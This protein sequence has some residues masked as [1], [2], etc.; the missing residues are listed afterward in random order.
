[1]GVSSRAYAV[2]KPGMQ[3]SVSARPE[4]SDVILLQTYTA[5][6]AASSLRLTKGSI[7]INSPPH[8]PRVRL[9]R[10]K[11]IFAP[12]LATLLNISGT[13]QYFEPIEEGMP[14]NCSRDAAL[15]IRAIDEV[16]HNGKE[17]NKAA[18][19]NAFGLGNLTDDDFGIISL[20]LWNWEYMRPWSSK[21][22]GQN[23][24][25]KWCDSIQTF[26]NGTVNTSP[27][28]VGLQQAITGYTT[29]IKSHIPCQGGACYSTYN[30]SRPFYT[31]QT[32]DNSL[33]QWMWLD[34]NELGWWQRNYSSIMSSLI[35]SEYYLRQCNHLFPNAD[36]T[37]GNFNPN[38]TG[39][40]T[41]Y[42]GW[43][44]SAQNLYVVNGQ[45]DPWRSVSLSSIWAPPQP[46]S[47]TIEVLAGGH[48]C[49]DWNL[50][51][52]YYNPDVKRVV[53]LG[54]DTLRGWLEAWYAA[55]PNITNSLPVPKPDVWVGI[56][57]L[58][59][60]PT[61]NLMTTA[62]DSSLKEPLR[63]LLDGLESSSG[64]EISKSSWDST[65][66][67]L[68]SAFLP[69][70]GEE[71]RSV[72]FLALSRLISNARPKPPASEASQDAATKDL[73]KLFAPPVE[74]RLSTTDVNEIQSAL[75]FLSALFQVDSAS[76]SDIFLRDGFIETIMESPELFEGDEGKSVSRGVASLLS[77]AC[78]SKPCR[79]TVSSHAST[80]LQD[81]VKQTTDTSLR[82]AAA[83][84]LTKLSRGHAED[85]ASLGSL[86]GNPK[87]DSSSQDNTADES[88]AL[89]MKSLILDSSASPDYA[90]SSQ[91]ILDAIEGLAYVSSDASTKELLSSDDAFLKRLFAL[92][93]PLRKHQ[94]GPK[95]IVNIDD[96]NLPPVPPRSS[97]AL[98][99]GIA[100]IIANIAAF[101][102]HLTEE[103]KQVERL[104]RMTKEGAK[105]GDKKLSEPSESAADVLDTDAAVRRRCKRLL[106]AGAI[107]TLVAISS[108]TESTGIRRA[109]GKAF[110]SFVEDKDNRGKIIQAG[111]VKALQN[112]IHASFAALKTESP[113]TPKTGPPQ[114]DTPNP[115]DTLDLLPIQ[116]LAKLTIT[117]SP[118]LIF[119]PD[120]SS[121]IPAIQPLSH[122]LLHPSSTLLQKFE[123]LMALTNLSSLGPP[124]ASKI[125]GYKEPS[126]GSV[127][128][129]AETLLLDDNT[130][131]RRAATEILCNLVASDEVW[132]R[133]TGETP[134]NEEAPTDNAI[135]NRLLI[136]IAMSDVEDTPTRLA[137]S[138]ALAMLTNSPN[139]ARV[140]LTHMQNGAEKAFRILSELLSPSSPP[141][142]EESPPQLIPTEVQSQLSHR[143]AVCLRNVLVNFESTNPS[144]DALSTVLT[145][146]KSSGVI[147]ALAFVLMAP[148]NAGN[149]DLLIAV[150][151]SLKWL[152]SHGVQIASA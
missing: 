112:I 70:A 105:G 68:F 87:N 29:F 121:S 71:A 79:S 109:V 64:I 136:L 115:L 128:Y 1:M 65:I 30:Y 147:E 35:T 78:G 22:Q 130:M 4:T 116:A 98:L 106:K 44:L 134:P 122:M 91:A 104:K 151:E 55:R 39:T 43:N 74:A 131:V 51:G 52:A 40:N 123:S 88:L 129:K 111:G 49:W 90:S 60:P 25:F 149:Q 113:E 118:L 102:P 57:H 83:I 148:E 103:E 75:G 12:S 82:A 108:R 66:S 138:G 62:G 63:D 15:V 23:A 54:I 143:A 107:P 86:G 31:D 145:E 46:P 17:E 95:P 34:C 21:Y 94:T 27:E 120:A 53:D 146:L 33:R 42:G 93:P 144:P 38:T 124:I 6:L 137:A 36:G 96:E 100:L 7:P 140:I 77:Q 99:Y 117:T 2:D 37:P 89:L 28:G 127:L 92:V 24:F 50:S 84:A 119:G 69:N 16:F 132:T 97:L 58:L 114:N 56:P 11:V 59:P 141:E 18:M 81:Q 139:V 8:G 67:P 26:S 61:S 32:A 80:W 10:L 41:V 152:M 3:L 76:A 73:S 126:L 5:P 47:Q 48:H 85:T 101:R 20:P 19:K 150:G 9:S 72:A 13:R 125:A 133:Y 45:Y 142:D 135:S 14:K 110:L